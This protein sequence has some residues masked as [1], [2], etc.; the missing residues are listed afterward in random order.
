[1]QLFVEDLVE[2]HLRLVRE[3][4]KFEPKTETVQDI[5]DLTLEVDVPAIQFAGEVHLFAGAYGND[6]VDKTAARANV[7]DPGVSFAR[8]RFQ[9]DLRQ[10]CCSLVFPGHDQCFSLDEGKCR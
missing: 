8:C 1:M 2:D 5:G 6:R 3:V 4:D 9:D 7:T 10:K